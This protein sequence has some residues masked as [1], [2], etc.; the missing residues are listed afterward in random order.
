MRPDLP[1]A[2]PAAT[3]RQSA[4]APPV[5]PLSGDVHARAQRA[6]YLAVGVAA[7]L[8]V[9]YAPTPP[10][11]P[12]PARAIAASPRP[13][14]APLAPVWRS[15]VDTLG[16]G[17][18]LVAVLTRAG[19]PAEEAAVA[20]RTVDG[21][22]ARVLRPGLTVTSR[23]LGADSVPAEITFM[24]TVDRVVRVRYLA[25][26]WKVLQERLAW[27]VDTVAAHGVVASSL[28]QAIHAAVGDRLAARE[29]SELAWR[30]ADILEY[31]V[32][33]SRDL[34]PGDSVALL[35]ERRVAPDGSPREAT[36]L[37]ASLQAGGRRVE[38]IRYGRG[39]GRGE[40]FDG[41]GK[42]L[43]AAFLRAP[44]EFR[45]VSSGFG[46]RR[47]PILGVW[48]AH[49]GTDYAAR[50]GT[51]VRAIGDGVVVR[52]GWYRGYGNT[53]EV[54]H[55]NG[56][57]TRY[58]HL[59]GFARGVRVGRTVGIGQTVAYV[60]S[61]GLS[62]APHLHF[63][64]LVGGVPRDPGAA[65]RER[66]GDP[67]PRREQPALAALRERLL[68]RIDGHPAPEARLALAE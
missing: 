52:A 59:R 66:S 58:G 67:L 23:V 17:E 55:R 6:T 7:A 10:T 51:P 49:R 14:Q 68:A 32:D 22:D 61:T 62:T 41:A 27:R 64:V 46:M 63:E 39:R 47:H 16:R 12:R 34:Q 45:R 33:M 35:V 56:F 36:I 38:A 54:R 9:Y 65:L 29:R 37:A 15:R 30:L 25:G 1:P 3:R 43:R 31:R 26:A 5:A 24:P 60:G 50:A 53:L 20:V 11:P 28:H 57:V 8:T 44:L 13:A 2:P 18:S 42:S 19:M 40:Y 4:A 48:K 21:A